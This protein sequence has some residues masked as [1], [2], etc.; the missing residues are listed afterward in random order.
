[1][2]GNPMN[3]EFKFRISDQ[4]E[5]PD[6]L[7]K[8]EEFFRGDSIAKSWSQS[9]S[10]IMKPRFRKRKTVESKDRKVSEKI[11]FFE[12]FLKKFWKN[13]HFLI[14]S[15]QIRWIFWDFCRYFFD[16]RRFFWEIFWFFAIFFK[17]PPSGHVNNSMLTILILAI[18]YVNN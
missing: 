6:A 12:F 3:N 14:F 15:V 4:C 17:F 1:M 16:F 9:F 18:F 13:Q 2:W 7:S 5:V 11:D 8:I 10:K